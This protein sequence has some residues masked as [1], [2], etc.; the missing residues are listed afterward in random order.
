MRL[1]GCWEGDGGAYFGVE[2]RGWSVAQKG[3]WCPL[4]QVKVRAF[5]L[6]SG[7]ARLR[8]QLVSSQDK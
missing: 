2:G 6:W 8:V 4:W 5:G 7:V 1:W 3:L